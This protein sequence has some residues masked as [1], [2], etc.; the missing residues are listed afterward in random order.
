L[1]QSEGA[2][3]QLWRDAEFLGLDLVTPKPELGDEFKSRVE[4]LIEERLAARRARDWATSDRLRGELESLG[5]ALKD[6]KDGT[7]WELRQ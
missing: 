3:A 6:S 2:A 7:T 1:A 5:V 4:H